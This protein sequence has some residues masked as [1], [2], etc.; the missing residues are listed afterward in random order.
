MIDRNGHVAGDEAETERGVRRHSPHL[1]LSLAAYPM[2]G[3]RATAV[4]WPEGQ[5]EYCPALG[6]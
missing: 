3:G 5:L 1:P 2:A 6:V 4:F